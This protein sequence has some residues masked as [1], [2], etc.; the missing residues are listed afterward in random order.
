MTR[1]ER[2]Q[3]AGARLLTSLMGAGAL[4][5]AAAAPVNAATATVSTLGELQTAL[6][7][8]A[9]AP[10]T[11]VLGADISAAGSGL[12]VPCDTQLDLSVFDL[13][14]RNVAIAAG[15]GLVVTGPTDG[16]EGTLTVDATGASLI[17]A[18]RTTDAT[19]SVTGGAIHAIGGYHG[20]AIG[21][22][23]DHSHG[24]LIVTA[25]TVLAETDA[26]YGAAIGGG[27]G[28]ATRGDGGTVAV[29]GGDVTAISTSFY[30]TAMGGGGGGISAGT[31]GH[32]PDLTVTG[33]VVRA[34]ASGFRSTAIG[35]GVFS[36]GDDTAGPG[37]N[38]VIGP[39]GTVIAASPRAA[40]GSGYG[41]APNDFGTVQVAGTLSL[42]GGALSI[43]DT[44]AGAEITVTSAGRI[45]GSDATPT[46]GASVSGAGQ[47]ANAGIIALA[48]PPTMVTGNN[49]LLTF[50]SGASDVRVF[51]PTVASGFR[52]LPTPPVGTKWNTASDGTGDWF[53]STSSTSG[54]GTTALYD[55]AP[56]SIEVSTDPADLTATA[57]EPFSFPVTVLGV[58]AD[59]LTPQPSVTFTSSD[60]TMEAGHVFEEARSCTIDAA[61]TVEGVTVNTSFQIDVVAAAATQL[62]LTPSATSVDQGG[63]LTFGVTGEDA[64]G[65]AADTSASV[66]TSSVTTDVITGWTVSFPHASPHTITATLGAATAS[67][68]IEV[69]PAAAPALG[70]TGADATGL[71]ALGG[72]GLALLIGGVLALTFRR[73][74]AR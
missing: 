35:G 24:T 8:C 9:T 29:S 38:I 65:N 26:S 63:S 4:V 31:A 40:L 56:G 10:N 69:V 58:D 27:Y 50:S 5:L 74:H 73:R 17:A 37:G 49:R 12:T 52:T 70:A 72:G 43:P 59:P 20:A 53:T 68:T 36:L 67:V 60:C 71:V 7:D 34:S 13:T 32:G 45:I 25:G 3:R 15:F 2:G 64:Y 62:T 39:A 6:A 21:G 16:T 42:P 46:V 18:I 57:G 55:V 11:I 54:S 30:G 44:D 28:I 48:P 33:G 61:A 1:P 23:A 14:V 47:I 22:D 66:L 41:S 51:A 19:L